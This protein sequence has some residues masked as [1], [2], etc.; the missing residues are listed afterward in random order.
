[1]HFLLCSTYFASVAYLLAVRRGLSGAPLKAI[2]LLSAVYLM[3]SA[4]QVR[5]GYPMFTHHF[6]TKH[7]GNSKYYIYLVFRIVPFVFEMR[8]LLDWTFTNTTLKFWCS[9]APPHA[10]HSTHT[11]HCPYHTRH[12]LP[13]Y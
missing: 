7:Y 8:S 5:M 12:C 4:Q 6:L 10:T 1:M 2:L 11:R 13:P 3:L 9:T